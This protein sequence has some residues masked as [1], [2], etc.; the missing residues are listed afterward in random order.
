MVSA[1][2][3][4]AQAK[5]ARQTIWRLFDQ[6]RLS[7][8]RATARLLAVDLAVLRGRAARQQQTQRVLRLRS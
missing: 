1:P 4:A 7:A 3:T 8:D 2:D 5:R 6:G